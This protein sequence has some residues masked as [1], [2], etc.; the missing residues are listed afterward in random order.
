V[1]CST[2]DGQLQTQHEYKQQQQYDSTG[3]NKKATKTKKTNQ[4][5]QFTL[6]HKLFKICACLQT[7]FAAETH[8]T[9]GHWLKGQLNMVKLRM[10]RVE[11][12]IL[13]VSRTDGQYLVYRSDDA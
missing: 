7:A 5:S 13:T 11:T 8:L 10:F 12:R 2:A 9:L 4:L 6:K 3:K 1:L